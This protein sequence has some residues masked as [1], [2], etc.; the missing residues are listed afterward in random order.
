M[1]LRITCPGGPV[2]ERCTNEPRRLLDD[3]AGMAAPNRRGRS[4]EVADGLQR[5]YIM[6]LR[7]RSRSCKSPSPNSTLTLLGAE[8]VRSNPATLTG[9][10]EPRNGAPSHAS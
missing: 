2:A 5:R 8:N 1:Q 3:H 4:L 10:L 9:L 6:R 7:T